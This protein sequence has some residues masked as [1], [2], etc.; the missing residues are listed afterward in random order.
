MASRRRRS[1]TIASRTPSWPER[2]APPG[3]LEPAHQHLVGSLEEQD[4]D[5]LAR[6][7]QLLDGRLQLAQ[8]AGVAADHQGQ[9]LGLGAAG[10]NQV[11]HLGDERGGQV[12]HHVPA[13]VL[14]G[15]TGLGTPR[16]RQPGDDDELGHSFQCARLI[17]RRGGDGPVSRPAGQAG[18]G[19]RPPLGT[20]RPFPGTRRGGR[21][22]H[23]RQ[24][25]PGG[26][27]AVDVDRKGPVDK[28]DPDVF[29]DF[30]DAVV[31]DQVGADTP[32]L[33]LRGCGR[34]PSRCPAPGGAGG[35]RTTGTYLRAG[36]PGPPR[37]GRR[38]CPRCAR[39]PGRR[40]RRRSWRREKAA[41]PPPP[42]RSCDLRARRGTAGG[43]PLARAPS[44]ARWGPPPRPAPRRG[45]RPRRATAGPR[46]S[47][48]RAPL[49]GRAPGR[50]A[51]ASSGIICSVYSGSAPS[52]KLR[53]HQAELTSHS[54]SASAGS[55]GP[56]HG[57]SASAATGA[58]SSDRS[59]TP[60]RRRSPRFAPGASPGRSCRRGSSPTRPRPRARQPGQGLEG[61]LGEPGGRP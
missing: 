18:G 4:R 14:E 26:G 45:R 51:R 7:P 43:L 20:R 52:V 30:F 32:V 6:G 10:G 55:G 21:L 16:S 53:C 37:P 48:C 57:T 8:L 33:L 60:A 49:P 28:G 50:G 39:R 46:R 17:G 13:Q 35:S 12:V 23:P 25:E 9:A 27:Q 3:P 56:G 58:A 40:R 29:V 42:G 54:C 36:A 31:L 59:A 19:R 47:R 15:G 38:P 41:P 2:V 22:D 34:P 11:G 44:W 61:L 5:P 24:V 1:S